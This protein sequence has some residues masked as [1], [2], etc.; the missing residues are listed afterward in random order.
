MPIDNPYRDLTGGDWLRGNLHAH[1]TRSDGKRSP[2]AVIDDYARR[3]YDFL[4]ISDHDVYTSPEDYAKLDA[5]GLALIPGN[6]ITKNGEH[7]LH[8]NANV[9]VDANPDRQIVLDDIAR[10]G[11]FAVINHPNWSVN[12]P[13]NAWAHVTQQNLVAWRG[14]AGIEIYNGV[15]GVHRGSQYALDRWDRLLSTGRRAWGFAHDDSHAADQVE[16]GWNVVYAQ[17]RTVAGIV[18]A[19]AQG[20]FYASTGVVISRI[21]V[22]GDT[23]RLETENADRIVATATGQRRFAVVNAKQIEFTVPKDELYV[24]FEC[25][26]RGEQFAWTQPFYLS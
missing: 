9:L 7:L 12:D 6:E 19:M 3:G 10:H 5:K 18:Q 13:E 21:E 8:V 17:Q 26:G 15:I 16:L 25:W 4:M 22:D 1:T 23:I 24:R 2:Q 20:R 14:Y 11:G